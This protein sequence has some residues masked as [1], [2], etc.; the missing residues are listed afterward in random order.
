M[1]VETLD[2]GAADFRL[3]YRPNDTAYAWNA[4]LLAYRRVR[5]T[6]NPGVAGP[7]GSF[8]HFA[9]WLAQRTFAAEPAIV[10]VRI[11]FRQL[12]V[13]DPPDGI[14]VTDDF[15]WTLERRR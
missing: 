9:D 5:A 2:R 15:L 10:A 3:R 13:G 6:W 11:R 4:S 12:H 14:T 8:D 7:R 1:H